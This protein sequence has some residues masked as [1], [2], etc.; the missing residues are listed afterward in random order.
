MVRES[1]TSAGNGVTNHCIEV[2]DRP[3]RL[4]ETLLAATR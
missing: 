3:H 2:A 1:L 4:L